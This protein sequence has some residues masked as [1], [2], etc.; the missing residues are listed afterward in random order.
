MSDP[1]DFIGE[2]NIKGKKSQFHTDTFRKQ[3][4]KEYFPNP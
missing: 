4:K 3:R 2:L 1:G